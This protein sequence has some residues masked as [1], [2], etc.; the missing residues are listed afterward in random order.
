MS[1]GRSPR[2]SAG[3]FWAVLLSDGRY[4]CG[5]VLHVPRKADPEPSLYLNTRIFLAGLMDWSGSAPPE[6]E[7]IA[8]CEILAQGRMHVAA[9]SDTGSTILGRQPLANRAQIV[10]AGGGIAGFR[11]YPEP[12]PI[13]SAPWVSAGRIS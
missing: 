7:A 6:G 3:Q 11:H 10:P 1:R 2:C 13:T 8:G 5:R 9:I 12:R 4:A